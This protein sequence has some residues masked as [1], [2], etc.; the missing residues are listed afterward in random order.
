[1]CIY[2]YS[3]TTDQRIV[4]LFVLGLTSLLNTLGQIATAPAGSCVTLTNVLPQRND[5]LPTPSQDTDTGHDYPPRHSIQT[6]DM[7]THHVTVYRHRT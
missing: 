5:M 7:T 2:T 4:C 1:M 3:I 6:Q